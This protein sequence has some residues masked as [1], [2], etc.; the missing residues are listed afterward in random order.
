MALDGQGRPH[1]SYYDAGLGDLKYAYWDGSSWLIQSVDS[2]GNVGKY[3]SL[4]LDP[5]GR[6]CISYYDETD[7]DLKVAQGFFGPERLYFPLLA[8]FSNSE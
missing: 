4:A 3:N 1:I 8:R 5:V 7:G 6:P 2:L